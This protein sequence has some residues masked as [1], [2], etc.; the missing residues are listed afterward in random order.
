[1]PRLEAQPR[2]NSSILDGCDSRCLLES[3]G[4]C[5]RGFSRL[6]DCN[7]L[8]TKAI[9]LTFVSPKDFE[10]VS[11]SH[12]AIKMNP[13]LVGFKVSHPRDKPELQ[14]IKS[15]CHGIW[16]LNRP[17]GLC[18][19]CPLRLEHSSPDPLDAAPPSGLSLCGTPSERPS[20]FTPSRVPSH[21]LTYHPVAFTAGAQSESLVGYLLL[22]LPPP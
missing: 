17:Q 3:T 14:A 20:L 11:P 13:N 10:K 18:T 21:S 22:N 12:H 16:S 6:H 19:R 1:M 7:S 2:Q 5:I 15:W 9:S 8:R 4:L